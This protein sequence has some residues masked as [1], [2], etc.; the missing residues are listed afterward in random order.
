MI[1][2]GLCG[3]LGLCLN[4]RLLLISFSTYAGFVIA[5]AIAVIVFVEL[6]P[7]EVTNEQ[8]MRMEEHLRR[9]YFKDKRVEQVANL[10]QQNFEC[11]GV[12]GTE[13]YLYSYF[14]NETGNIVPQSCCQKYNLTGWNET[15]FQV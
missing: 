13:D 4:N 3:V 8:L 5:L 12:N 6:Y 15:D 14:Y 7:F 9:S 10:A 1:L 2:S 11:C